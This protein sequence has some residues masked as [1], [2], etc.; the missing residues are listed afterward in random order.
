V[1]K[2]L[3]LLFACIAC[4]LPAQAA[5][6]HSWQLTSPDHAQTF[7]F[8]TE[9]NRV[10]KGW[11]GRLLLLLDF[12]NDPHVDRDNPRSYDSFRFDFP[13]VRIG[14]DGRTFYYHA[15]DG[16]LIPVAEKKAGFLGIE[17][18]KLLSNA[19][20]VVSRPHGYITVYLNVLDP[21]GLAVR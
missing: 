2:S 5:T 16:R 19:N 10:W 13:G 7:S 1:R 17:E 8:G 18:I 11:G 14:A 15:S 4:L 12:T 21:D 20:V 6:A 3:A 9:T